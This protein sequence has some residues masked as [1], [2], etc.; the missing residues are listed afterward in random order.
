MAHVKK[1]STR[2]FVHPRRTASLTVPGERPRHQ[3]IGVINRA[4][5]RLCN[6]PRHDDV[7]EYDNCAVC[8]KECTPPDGLICEWG[9]CKDPAAPGSER[10][11][12]HEDRGRKIPN[13]PCATCDDSAT[14]KEVDGRWYCGDCCE[15]AKPEA[16]APCV[17]CGSP[18]NSGTLNGLGLSACSNPKCYCYNPDLAPR[19]SIE[20]RLTEK[21]RRAGEFLVAFKGM[22]EAL[23]ECLL[24]S[25]RGGRYGPPAH[26]LDKA[27]A[28]LALADKVKP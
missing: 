19:E 18:M 9:D 1:P 17:I 11:Q 14:H 16:H 27:R 8:K 3:A 5:G 6:D 21:G 13:R 20:V 10:C 26:T 25:D 7:C 2:V 28:A 23:R 4:L 15:H 22:R 24:N 12:A